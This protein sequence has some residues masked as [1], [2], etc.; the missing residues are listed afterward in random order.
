MAH[1]AVLALEHRGL[2][3]QRRARGELIEDQAERLAVGVEFGD[4]VAEVLLARVAEHIELALVGPQDHPVRA[5]PVHVNAQRTADEAVGF[6][7]AEADHRPQER[8]VAPG[9]LLATGHVAAVEH[10]AA[11]DLSIV[12]FTRHQPLLAIAA[13]NLH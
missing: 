11:R 4:V 1:R 9:Q 8:Q 13:R 12:L 10:A 5:D 3:V 6:G 2:V 7:R